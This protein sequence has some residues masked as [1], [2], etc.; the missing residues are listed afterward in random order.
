MIKSVKK[1]WGYEEWLV[2]T[3]LYCAKILAVKYGYQCSLH[4]HKEKDESFY[5]LKGCIRLELENKIITLKPNDCI[6][7]KPK[8]KHRFT[9]MTNTS[10]ILE[11]ST[12][13]ED[14]DSYRT[15]QGGKI[16]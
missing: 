3:E 4:H 5:C 8:E 2:N 12:H 15:I 16:T 10:K 9:S 11:V 7:I 13:H 1:V 14:S 6:R